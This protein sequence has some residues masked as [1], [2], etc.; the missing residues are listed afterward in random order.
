MN[1]KNKN[2]G[3][4]LTCDGCRQGLQEYLD[5]TLDKPESLRFF[6]HLR[7]CSSCQAD[8][9]R[10]QGLFRMLDSLP[11]HEVPA[12]FDAAVLAS[13]PYA[14]YQAMEPLRRERV[15]VFLEEAFLPR[16]VRARVTRL[17]GFGVAAISAALALRGDGSA[18]LPVL[19]VAGL[20]PE[21]LVR[22]QGLGRRALESMGRA[23]S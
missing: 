2:T 22:L 15:P 17:A 3:S 5:G 20:V 8:H 11:D 14:A 1:G 19:V 16:F 7:E 18:V 12:D 23:E 10:M 21:I 4:P 13:V 9:D 6:L